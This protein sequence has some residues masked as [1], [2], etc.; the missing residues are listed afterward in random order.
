MIA[1]TF[2]EDDGARDQQKLDP[3]LSGDSENIAEKPALNRDPDQAQD[4]VDHVPG[5][6]LAESVKK[7]AVRPYRLP[8]P[9]RFH[10]VVYCALLIYQVLAKIRSLF[11]HAGCISEITFGDCDQAELRPLSPSQFRSRVE[12]P[13]CELW[14]DGVDNKGQR[15]SRE[16]RCS[17]DDA[18]ALMG[19]REAEQWLPRISIL[20]AACILTV[21]KKGTPLL[22]GPGYHSALG[23]V[24]ITARSKPRKTGVNEAV[25][26]L[27]SI[28]RDFN[29]AT[30]S[31]KARMI[32]AM[33]TPALIYGKLLKNEA[34]SP[35]FIIEANSSRA[36]KG[37]FAALVAAIYGE[38]PSIV[39]PRTGGIGSFDEDFSSALLRGRPFILLDNLRRPVDSSH[40]E[41]F[42]TSPGPF[43]AR[44]FR[45]AP[46]PVDRS[47]YVLFAT[48][49]GFE[50]GVDLERR[51]V[52]IM[53]LKRPQA[54]K[55]DTYAGDLDVLSYVRAHQ[56]FYL[57]CVHSIVEAWIAAG[58]PFTRESRHSFTEWVKP[59]DWILH[60]YFSNDVPAR[61]M[62]FETI[63]ESVDPAAELGFESPEDPAE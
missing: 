47:R 19:T 60:E 61:M 55:F 24:Y 15:I 4:N 25:N 42:M 38:H 2:P 45:R 9:S 7:E 41:S 18:K 12:I 44:G 26:A 31:D 33:V 51:A 48:S 54:Y 5:L 59:L 43:H 53:L 8:L 14:K 17:E 21:C 6:P 56:R 10:S 63:P 34:R 1:S 58:R 20:S 37:Y 32:A 27:L 40:I 23:G 35:L 22:L 57:G 11:I 3:A 30:T 49:N 52:R 36:G 28:I 39:V 29:P 62:D 46:A 50:T 13:G 16:A